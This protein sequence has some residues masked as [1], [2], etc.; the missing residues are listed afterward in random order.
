[1][2]IVV[3]IKQVPDTNEVKPVSYTHLDTVETFAE[4]RDTCISFYQ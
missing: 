2:K 3:C 4:I 1:M